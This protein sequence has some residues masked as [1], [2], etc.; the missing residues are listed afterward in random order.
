MSAWRMQQFGRALNR[1]ATRRWMC[2]WCYG[3]GVWA[4]SSM[5]TGASVAS[6]SFSGPEVLKLNWATRSLNVSDFNNDGLND[7]A[8]VNNDIAQIEILYQRGEAAATRGGK[9]RLNHNRWEPQLEDAR[10]EREGITIGFPVFDLSV[11]D[12][13]GDGRDDLAYTAREV[14]LTIRYQDESGHWTETHEFDDFEALGWTQTVKIAD[15]DGDDR[16]ELVVIS[17]DALRVFHQDAH[18]Q[19]GDP[20][21]Y[22]LTGNNPFNLLLEDVTD[23]GRADVLYITANGDQSLALREQLADGGFGPERRFALE[24]P[25]RSVRA[26]PRAGDEVLSFCSVDSRSGGLE[27]F[28]LQQAS[29]EPAVAGF[30]AAQPEIYPIF[31]KG[32]SSASY[33]WGD[34][35]GDGLEDLLVANPSGA[36]L[37]LFLK[38]GSHFRT[39]Q[40]FPSFSAI[41]SITSGHFFDDNRDSVVVISAAEKT[42]GVSHLNQGGRI[43]FPRQL[44]VGEGDPLVCRAVDLDADGYDELALVGEVKGEM[45]LTLARPVNRQVPGSEWTVLSRTVLDGV[46]RKPSAIRAVDIFADGRRGLMVFVPREAPVLLLADQEDSF[47]FVEVAKESTIRES[48]LKGI[49]Q[50]Q[51]SVFDVD[52]DGINELVVG[53]SGYARAVSVK[54]GD[55][56]MVDQFNAR[57]GDEMVSAVVPLYKQGA[58]AQLVFYIESAGEFQFLERDPDGVF[59]YRTTHDAGSIKLK[60]WFQL[61]DLQGQAAYVFAGADR[62]WLLPSMADVWTRVAFDRYETELKDVH[63]S[64]VVGADFD[65]DGHLELV[66]VD[67]KSHVVEVLAQHAA[68]WS[69]RMF[70]QVFE[71]NMH[72][73]GR[74][75]GSVE[76]RQ[77]VLADLTGDGKVD[78]ALLVHDRVLFYPQQ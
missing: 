13:N 73:Q 68:S 11:G 31:K 67:G 29:A 76:P 49:K 27:F 33:A 51:V 24:R 66:A 61:D 39:P 6:F 58:L 50:S 45:S 54:A 63:Y 28:R 37:L 40:T 4:A 72:Y 3:V 22:Y 65:R 15:I 10:F 77:V 16:A 18:G 64:H 70:W 20:E 57:R 74:T 5:L 52:G 48:L 32:R 21:L 17:G 19:L 30:A 62:F 2:S 36:E 59:R 1:V 53:R 42:V 23:D 7:L 9:T 46:K 71:Q 55:L 56:E 35:D 78:L 14:S 44:M 41:S 12:L 26:L 75:G 25:V 38:E 8:V 34:F 43:A 69:S 47:E 60:Q